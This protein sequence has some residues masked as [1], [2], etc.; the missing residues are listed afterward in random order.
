MVPIG[1]TFVQIAVRDGVFDT[2]VVENVEVAAVSGAADTFLDP[3]FREDLYTVDVD[4]EEDYVLA[5]Y[6]NP[7]FHQQVRDFFALETGSLVIADI[8]LGAAAKHQIPVMLAFSLA[9]GES[10]FNPEAVNRNA[11]SI[12]RGLFQL[13]S[14]SFPDLSEHQFFD[15]ELNA[16]YGMKYL[17]YCLDVG[18][19]R[20][21]ALAMY[22]AGRSRVTDRGAPKMT[23]DYISKIFD[24]HDALEERF[25]DL[26]LRG[27]SISKDNGKVRY[28][29]DRG[30][31]SK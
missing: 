14:R 8:I 16:E 11:Y 9:W 12:D 31:G 21:V 5:L 29:L 27:K 4:P 7:L 18:D 13:N 20:L 15:P 6:R 24:Y 22:N 23:L 26:H 10:R 17:R 2:P 19:N 1:L 25:E 30:S 28:V 3:F